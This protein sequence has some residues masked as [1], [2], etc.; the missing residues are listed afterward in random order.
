MKVREID[1]PDHAEKTV[2]VRDKVRSMREHQTTDAQPP[3]S[4]KRLLFYS[5]ILLMAFIV[6][7]TTLIE[8]KSANC[9]YRYVT[10]EYRV[11]V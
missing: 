5:L 3:S 4:G 1:C 11:V 10:Y 2:G 7:Q 9:E 8:L 6:A